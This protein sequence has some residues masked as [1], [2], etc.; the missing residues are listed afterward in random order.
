M[1]KK[2]PNLYVNKIE[3]KLANN[4][5]VFYSIL[6]PNIEVKEEIFTV[7]SQIDDIV[8]VNVKEKVA[9]LFNS[10]NYVYKMNVTITL[11]DNTIINKDVIGQVDNKLITIDEDLIEINDIRDIKF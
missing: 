10:T 6:K 5:I 8:N 7:T 4:D 11:K 2:L 9:D 1:N 3:R